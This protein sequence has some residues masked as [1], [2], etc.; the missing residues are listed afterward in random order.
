MIALISPTFQVSKLRPR[1]VK[2][3]A[4]GLNV[5]KWQ[6]YDLRL[7]CL[8]PEALLPMTALNLEGQEMLIGAR[9]F[10]SAGF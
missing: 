4:E 9:R 6:N 7:S 3:L 10:W 1:E 8:A 2:Q 5:T